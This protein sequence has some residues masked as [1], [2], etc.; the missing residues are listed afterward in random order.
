MMAKQVTETP[1]GLSAHCQRLGDTERPDLSSVDAVLEEL[2]CAWPR[3]PD[4]IRDLME[5]VCLEPAFCDIPVDSVGP[6]R[7]SSLSSNEELGKIVAFWPTL[8][9][10]IRRSIVR[11]ASIRSGSG[12]IRKP[13]GKEMS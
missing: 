10:V 1:S 13:T 4:S 9:D 8:P 2:I 11:L 6:S 3:L 5:A 12:S 7:D